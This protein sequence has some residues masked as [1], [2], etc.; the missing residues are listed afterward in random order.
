MGAAVLAVLGTLL[1]LAGAG[2]MVLTC[3]V[4]GGGFSLDLLL[5]LLPAGVPVAL[6]AWILNMAHGLAKPPH[7]GAS[8]RREGKELVEPGQRSGRR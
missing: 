3:M 7:R 6:G 1:I 8:A 2:G 4:M 5:V